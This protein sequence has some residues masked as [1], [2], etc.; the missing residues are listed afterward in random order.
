M[1]MPVIPAIR[2]QK[3]EDYKFKDSIGYIKSPGQLCH[4]VRPCL[5]TSPSQNST[6]RRYE[7]IQALYAST[8]SRSEHWILEKP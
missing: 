2:T 6:W 5:I 3:H 1:V 8:I 4:L 7:S